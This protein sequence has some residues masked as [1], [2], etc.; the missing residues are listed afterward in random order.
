MLDKILMEQWFSDKEARVYLACLELWNAPASSIARKIWENRITTYSVLKIL[1]VRWIA[2][3]FKKWTV[4]YYSVVSPEKLIKIEELKI[5]RLKDVLP[6]LTWLMNQYWSKPKIY[7]YEWMDAL[8]WLFVDIILEW[9][10]TQNWE[11]FLTFLWTSDIDP[12]FQDYL[13]KEFVPLR[14]KY[15]TPTK[16]IISRI[17]S[18]YADYNEKQH[19]TIVVNDPIFEMSNE[20][21][22]YGS[23]KVAILMYSPKEMSGIVIDS[24]S[25][26]NWIKNL[27]NLIWKNYNRFKK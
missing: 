23:S 14:L 9:E 2:Y 22:V 16:A 24:M 19:D 7:Y 4:R 25:L 26:Y 15:T 12:V 18:D 21:V 20:I 13:T 17:G 6:E 27:F 11:P 3:E 8:K 1:C 10:K 5:N